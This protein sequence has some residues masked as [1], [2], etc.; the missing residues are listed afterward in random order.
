M[1]LTEL[2]AC[3]ATRRSSLEMLLVTSLSLVGASAL[4]AETITMEV[5][6]YLD[7]DAGAVLDRA[8]EDILE[9]ADADIELAYHADRAPHAVVF[10]IGEGS[11]LAFV[12]DTAFDGVTADDVANLTFSSEG[13]DLPFSANVCVVIRTGQGVVYK[14]GNASE[15]GNSVTFN[16]AIL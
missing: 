12:A 3:T 8:P 9:P 15:S 14:L 11:E 2:W 7:L 4:A 1:K 6:Q 10:P 13:I 16:Y 5:T